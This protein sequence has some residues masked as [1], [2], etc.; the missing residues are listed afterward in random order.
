MASALV[1][2]ARTMKRLLTALPLLFV[3]SLLAG[4]PQ[5]KVP[6]KPPMIPEPKANLSLERHTLEI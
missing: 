1:S 3:L 4:C 6:D 2:G 5:S